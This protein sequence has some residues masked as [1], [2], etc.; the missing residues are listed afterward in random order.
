MFPVS[1]R[2]L[3]AI[4]GGQYRTAVQA[5]IYYNGS[6]IVTLPITGGNVVIDRTSHV[7]RTLTATIASPAFI[8][9]FASSAISP[10]GTEVRL[11]M[12]I[13]FPDRRTEM[14]PMGRFE[15]YSI[16]WSDGAGSIPTLTGYDYGKKLDDAVMAHAIDRSGAA[17]LDMIT[18]FVQDVLFCEVIA[19][20][21]LKNYVLPGGS[22]FDNNR[23]DCIQ[24]VLDPMGAEAFFDVFGNFI[25]QPIP[26]VTSSTTDDDIVWTIDAGPNGVMVDA[27]RTVSREGTY[28]FV[29]AVGTATT[30]T[31]PPPIG[32][33]ADNDPASPT[34]WGPASSVPDGPFVSTPFGDVVLRY[35]NDKMTT[36]AQ[37]TAAAKGQLAQVLGVSKTLALDCAPNVALDAGDIIKV[38]FLN[39]KSEYHLVDSITIDIGSAS[40]AATTRSTIG[41]LP[42]E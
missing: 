20:D 30:D 5:D 7:R 40:F 17:A 32:Y 29:T 15:V 38:V 25:I 19:D 10:Y 36:S 11:S 35:E 9:L 8:P 37:C 26:S 16:S 34:Y 3:D 2:F 33:A 4:R 42:L 18:H 24:Q 12:G 21:S 14:V 22:I 23:W 1:G 27:N 13:T 41:Q 28:N 6:F 39:A 31:G